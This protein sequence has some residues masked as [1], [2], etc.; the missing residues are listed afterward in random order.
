VLMVVLCA[1]YIGSWLGLIA[2]TVRPYIQPYIDWSEYQKSWLKKALRSTTKH[3]RSC[4][5]VACFAAAIYHLIY[6]FIWSPIYASVDLVRGSIMEFLKP[7]LKLE[8]LRREQLWRISA[9]RNVYSTHWR[10]LPFLASMNLAFELA[11]PTGNFHPAMPT[12]HHLDPEF[13]C[14]KKMIMAYASQ[15]HH[16]CQGRPPE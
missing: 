16:I 11:G 3:I 1:H 12:M 14:P 13:L 5:I 9:S 2:K 6:C 4:C 8:R 7:D 10:G 15:V